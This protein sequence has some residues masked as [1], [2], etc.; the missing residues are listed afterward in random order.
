MENQP[1]NTSK[2][3]LNYERRLFQTKE[4]AEKDI[5]NYSQLLNNFPADTIDSQR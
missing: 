2:N 5:K 3:L 1:K 4:E